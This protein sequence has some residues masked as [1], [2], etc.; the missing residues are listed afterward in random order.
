MTNRGELFDSWRQGQESYRTNEQNRELLASKHFTALVGPAG[1][2]KS[3]AMQRATEIDSSFTVVG[4]QTSRP[5]RTNDNPALY[6]Y[7]ITDEDF[8]TLQKDIEQKEVI[9]YAID[10]TND[11]IYLSRAED[12]PGTYNLGDVWASAVPDFQK[13]GFKTLTTIALVAD[14]VDWES[15]FHE[16][17]QTGDETAKKRIKEAQLALPMLIDGPLEL[18]WLLNKNGDLD[19][20]ARGIIDLSRGGES[21]IDGP[22]IAKRMLEATK[23]LQQEYGT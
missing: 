5:Q 9:Q 3:T 15:W 20:T 12:Y 14:P 2:G 19:Q 22:A 8:D 6:R 11:V 17:F 21:Q 23:R 7:I 10:P 1:I 18:K 4:T 13:L 16:R